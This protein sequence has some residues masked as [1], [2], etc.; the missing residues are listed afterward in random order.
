MQWAA[1]IS[2]KFLN[3]KTNAIHSTRSESFQF[4]TLNVFKQLGMKRKLKSETVFRLDRLPR[5]SSLRAFFNQN[6][7]D[8]I[9]SLLTSLSIKKV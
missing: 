7:G 9:N 4:M 6:N 5:S 1:T 3:I 8:K 2:H